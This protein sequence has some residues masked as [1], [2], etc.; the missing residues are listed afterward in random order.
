MLVS[1]IDLVTNG[2][3]AG[4]S[5]RACADD[6]PACDGPVLGVTN[7]AGDVEIS[8]V[9]TGCLYFDGAD[10]V[11]SC[12]VMEDGGPLL[13]PLIRR[14]DRDRIFGG[15]TAAGKGIVLAFVHDCT[16]LPGTGAR[17]VT[18]SGARTLYWRGGRLVADAFETDASGIAAMIDL[19]APERRVVR[20]ELS[21]SVPAIHQL[22]VVVRPD[23]ITSLGLEP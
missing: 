17:L 8:S 16:G 15:Q 18:T 1:A 22:E 21:S 19:P 9:T 14:S 6:A 2:P 12:V 10:L 13:A 7:A 5:V 3:L 4:V 23:I 20:A 11:P